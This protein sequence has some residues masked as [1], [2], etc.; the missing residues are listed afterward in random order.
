MHRLTAVLTLSASLLACAVARCEV[1]APQQHPEPHPTRGVGAGHI[2]AHG[3]APVR[4]N[5]RPPLEHPN[6]VDKKG[7]PEALKA[8]GA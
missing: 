6:L 7:H 4:G 8:E 1:S 5:P 2:P 3:P